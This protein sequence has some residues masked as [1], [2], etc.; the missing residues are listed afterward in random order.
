MWRLKY[1]QAHKLTAYDLGEYPCHP[2]LGSSQYYTVSKIGEFRNE[3]MCGQ[4]RRGQV[5]IW[6]WQ[7]YSSSDQPS[8]ELWPQR[9]QFW[10]RQAADGGVQQQ[11]PQ[12]E[13]EPQ[14]PGRAQ[15]QQHRAVSGHGRG[16][17]GSGGRAHQVW[18]FTKTS[19]GLW[20]LRRGQGGVEARL[21]GLNII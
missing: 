16:Q 9:A 20:L 21:G 6:V 15:A 17:A 12:P 7:Y 19:L 8:G 1:I 4:V 10:P 11:E 14:P 13:V 18:Q 2:F 5:I 3:Y